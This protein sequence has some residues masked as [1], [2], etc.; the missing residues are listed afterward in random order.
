MTDIDK[1][2]SQIEIAIIQKEVSIVLNEGWGVHAVND[3]WVV[4]GKGCCP[5]G[6]VVAGEE[7][8]LL[9]WLA[10]ELLGIT[11]IE[12]DYFIEGFDNGLPLNL[13]DETTPLDDTSGR[14]MFD[15]GQEFRER[16]T[17]E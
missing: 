14:T 7:S 17:N 8:D 15:L 13:L 1:V 12:V 5:M 11:E 3:R 4:E 16:Y 10:A 2:R 6:A 9:S